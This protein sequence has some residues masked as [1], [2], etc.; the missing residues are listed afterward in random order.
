M[1]FMAKRFSELSLNELYEILKSRA[2]VFLLEQNNVYQDLDDADYSCLHCFCKSGER[3]VAYMRAYQEEQGAVVIGRV[4][5]LERGKG[6]GRK[7]AK[8]C[9][10]EIKKSFGCSKIIVYAQKCAVGFYEKLGFEITSDEF[11]KDGVVRVT[12]EFDVL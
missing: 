9:I 2:E 7:F 8:R 12:M 1:E 5:T 4:L 10:G 6:I 11:I 3:V